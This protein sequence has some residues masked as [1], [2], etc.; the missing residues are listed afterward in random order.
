MMPHLLSPHILHSTFCFASHSL[1]LCPVLL[2]GSSHHAG[3]ML[4]SCCTANLQ[5]SHSLAAV[6]PLPV[7]CLHQPTLSFPNTLQG[8]LPP[9]FLLSRS[10]PTLGAPPLVFGFHDTP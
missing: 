7:L 2:P 3:P 6:L 1:S 10:S 4:G 9:I 5:Q 8:S